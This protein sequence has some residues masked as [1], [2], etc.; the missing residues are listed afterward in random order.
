MTKDSGR[1]ES[2]NRTKGFVPLAMAVASNTDAYQEKLAFEALD[3]VSSSSLLREAGRYHRIYT[4]RCS[5]SHPAAPNKSPEPQVRNRIC[6]PK[7][8]G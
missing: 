4:C 2:F 5:P 8:W 6:L 3:F 7:A 1:A